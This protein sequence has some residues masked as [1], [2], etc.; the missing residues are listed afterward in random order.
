M[1]Q[2]QLSVEFASADQVCT[3][4][5]FIYEPKILIVQESKMQQLKSFTS[6]WI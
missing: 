2:V 1:H 6:K 4:M 3:G 5:Y